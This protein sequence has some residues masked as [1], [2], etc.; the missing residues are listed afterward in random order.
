MSTFWGSVDKR[1]LDL[2][3][4]IGKL[5]KTDY[6]VLSECEFIELVPNNLK[7]LMLVFLRTHNTEQEIITKPS[8]T[9]YE[10]L[11]SDSGM[12]SEDPM[13]M[14]IALKEYKNL[15][16]SISPSIQYLFNKN[17]NV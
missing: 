6:G 3:P 13:K 7:I 8:Q 1:F 17:D 9:G 16:S 5:N 15:T 2:E 10:R 12:Y 4:Y 11:T 14:A